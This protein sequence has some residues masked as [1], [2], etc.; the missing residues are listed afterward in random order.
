MCLLRPGQQNS[1]C[2]HEECKNF[3]LL[4]NKSCLYNTLDKSQPNTHLTKISAKLTQIE[5]FSPTQSS[6]Q[7]SKI[8]P[9]SFKRT[10]TPKSETSTDGEADSAVGTKK[11]KYDGNF[12]LYIEL[13]FCSK[14]C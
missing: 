6:T 8:S 2:P 3:Y 9:T 4:K 14:D 10:P 13:I 7:A 1:Q 5:S 11:V 12:E